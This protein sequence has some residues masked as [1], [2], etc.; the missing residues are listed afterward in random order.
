MPLFFHRHL[1]PEGELGIWHITEPAEYFESRLTLR[2]SEE[3]Q[4]AELKGHR[5]LEWLA[6]RW[7]L[8][9]MSGREERGACL[10]DEHGKPHLE[11]SLY[12]ISISHSR[13][14]AAIMAAPRTVGVD[15][16]KLVTKIERIAHKYM[17]EE[18][19]ASLQ[20]VSRLVHLHVYWG[21]K[22]ALY[23]AYGRRQLDFKAH[24]HIAPFVFDPQGGS[25]SGEIIKDDYRAKY[26]IYYEQFGEYIL[27]HAMEDIGDQRLV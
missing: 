13:E 3:A 17:R 10:K 9:E 6:G 16:Q 8:H 22:E 25:F 4:L 20:P 26:K 23:K 27:V 19:S 1:I 2:P 7:L 11:G 21:A 5:R 14:M 24:I 18:E 12:D 15:I